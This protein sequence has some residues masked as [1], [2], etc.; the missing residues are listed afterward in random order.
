M[1]IALQLQLSPAPLRD[2]A[3]WFLAGKDPG[4]WLE[5]LARCGL[6]DTETR[7]FIVA[8]SVTERTVAGVLVI[9][10]KD[11]EPSVQ[12]RGLP[13][14]MI[15]DRLFM[16]VDAALS[17]PLTD[18]E[19]KELCHFPVVFFHPTFGLSAFENQTGLRICDLLEVPPT[20]AENWNLA[21]AAQ[22]QPARFRGI[23]LAQPPTIEQVFGE[24]SEDIG[25]EADDP[26]PPAPNEPKEDP[27]S[28]AA[29]R[30]RKLFARNVS[31]L[32]RQLP[33][34]GRRTWLNDVEDWANRQLRGV[35]SQL[36]KLRNKELHRLL[37]LLDEDP[38][39][40]TGWLRLEMAG[41]MAFVPGSAE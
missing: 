26:L 11:R 14:G 10:P 7:L 12:P 35:S 25:S 41:C 13:C 28:K 2:V 21:T 40:A 38:E 8:K 19:V 31:D 17:P 23:I 33:H 15:A 29:R 22:T 16:P 32:L 9:P 3:A 27:L 5:E 1:L 37:H 30:A 34:R 36:D 6:A 24:E 4:R 18:I 39:A 20:R